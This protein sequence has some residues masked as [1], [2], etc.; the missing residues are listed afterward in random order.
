MNLLRKLRNLHW[1]DRLPYIAVVLGP[2]ALFVPDLLRGRALFWGT[3]L[4]QFVPWRTYA[5]ELLRAGEAPLWNDLLGMGAP[6]LANYQSALLYPPTM[7][8]LLTGPALGNGLLVMLHLIWTGVGCVLLARRLRLRILGQIVAGAAFSLCGY[9]VARGGFL[10]IIATA[11]WLP[12][13]ILA[14]E[15]LARAQE[16]SGWSRDTTKS[17]AV[18]GFVFAMQWLAGHA[19][20]AW[21]S[22]LLA[23]VWGVWR[24]FSDKG[25]VGTGWMTIVLGA[26]G[27]F[28]FALAAV[29]LLPTLEY[30]LQSQRG[31][32]LEESFAL[33]YSFWPWRLLTLLAPNLFGNPAGAGYWGYGN[34]WEDAVYIGILPFLLACRAIVQGWR[35]A[36]PR[37]RLIRFLAA[38]GLVAFTFAL[39]KNTPIFI[40]LFRHLP[41]FG[42]FQA[43]TRWNLITV[44][45]LSLLAGIGADSWERPS[46]R[47]KYWTRLGMAGAAIVGVAA[48]AASRVWPDIETSFVSAFARM[49]VWFFLFGAM[50][51]LQPASTGARWWPACV[52]T[53][54]VVDLVLLGAGLNP[55]IGVGVF[56]G[57]S[58]LLEK[59]GRDHRIYMP[60]EIEYDV[61]FV[62]THRFDRFLADFDWSYVRDIGLPNTTLLDRIPSANN[63]DPLLPARYS[64]WMEQLE[65]LPEPRKMEMLGLM[66]VGWAAVD[67]GGIHYRPI[68]NP[69]RVRVLSKARFVESNASA[70]TIVANEGFD[71]EREI[72]LEGEPANGD[73]TQAGT[74]SAVI[75]PT[76][77]STEVR[78][79]VSTTGGAWLQLSDSWY[80][81]WKVYV[82]DRQSRLYRSDGFFR[83]VWVPDGDHSVRFRYQ[84]LS[85]TLGSWLSLLAWIA[86]LGLLW[87]WR[88]R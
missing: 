24:V 28:G 88:P 84:P 81:G 7:L 11:A 45:A 71:P 34:Y 30:L 72:V 13:L 65:E 51:M 19:Q 62:Q 63:F 26:G 14:V 1:F 49:G 36:S 38:S 32:T 86:L 9:L 79:K 68:P 54:V 5:F 83:A 57:E 55:T 43:P 80:P 25:R 22:L 41:T 64:Q 21:Y 3:P 27:L 46:E 75:E 18:L 59:V 12:W 87:R 73:A 70:I 40:Y 56:V 2:V 76:K 74:G 16:R 33:T 39:G 42:L 66:D 58:R 20:T 8:L 23:F 47:G 69:R 67:D 17:I 82:D 78:V 60:P 37:S 77:V 6:L 15:R 31:G 4:L 44:F 48:W 52:S 35:G 61:K 50:H 29:Q 10:S 85:F 53:L